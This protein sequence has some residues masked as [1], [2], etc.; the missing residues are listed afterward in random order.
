MNAKTDIT[1]PM[2]LF[3]AN[4]ELYLRIGRLLQEYNR[5]WLEIASRAS[6]DGIAESGAQIENL[7]KSN[8]WQA[9]ATLPS[10][11]IW[12]QFQQRFGDVQATAQIAV[13]AQTAFTTDLQQ[14]IHSWQKATIEAA[15]SDTD[16]TQPFNDLFKQWS[17]MWPTAMTSKSKAAEKGSKP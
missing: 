1:L 3:K 10:E 6:S 9:L 17:S 5:R 11:A 12:R 13:S 4:L 2:N 7:L 15:G 8:N 14:A 16:V